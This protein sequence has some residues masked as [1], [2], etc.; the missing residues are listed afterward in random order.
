M[1][2]C[3]LRSLHVAAPSEARCGFRNVRAGEFRNVRAVDKAERSEVWVTDNESRAK[4]GVCYAM[5]VFIIVTLIFSHSMS[6][7]PSKLKS[8]LLL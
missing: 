6:K 7:T 8:V 3:G 5:L 1:A 2:R 4:R